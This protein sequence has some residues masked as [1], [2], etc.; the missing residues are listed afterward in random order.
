LGWGGVGWGWLRWGKATNYEFRSLALFFFK[1]TVGDG[2]YVC[3]RLS[4]NQHKTISD[5]IEKETLIN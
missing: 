5:L 4:L 2:N 1:T 3:R